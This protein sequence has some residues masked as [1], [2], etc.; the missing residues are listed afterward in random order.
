MKYHQKDEKEIEKKMRGFKNR[1]DK[2]LVKFN[3]CV[4]RQRSKA[5]YK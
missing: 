3:T 2:F 4:Y 5:K 1:F